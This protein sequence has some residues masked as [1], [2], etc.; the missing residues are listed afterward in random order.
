MSSAVNY[1]APSDVSM[2]VR[3]LVTFSLAMLRRF[4]VV[5]GDL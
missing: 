4:L 1:M 3:I 2:R 5:P